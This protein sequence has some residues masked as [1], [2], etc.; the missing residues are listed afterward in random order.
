[1]STRSPAYFNFSSSAFPEGVLTNF[2]RNSGDDPRG[3]SPKW[4]PSFSPTQSPKNSQKLQYTL[5]PIDLLKLSCLSPKPA[6]S[7]IASKAYT[8]VDFME[9]FRASVVELR[10]TAPLC[11]DTRQVVSPILSLHS[12]TR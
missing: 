11:Q 10:K 2:G 4:L 7:V 9:C 1:M 5:S 6:Q 3:P 8:N 12:A